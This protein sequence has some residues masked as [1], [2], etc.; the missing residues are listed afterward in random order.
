MSFFKSKNDTLGMSSP[1]TRRDFVNGTLA[2]A[3][4]ALMG[5]HAYAVAIRETPYAPSGSSWTGYGGIGDY[6][7][8]NGNTEAVVTA[9]HGIRDQL[10]PN[11]TENSAD[12]SFDLIIVGGGFSGMTAAYEFNKRA[13]HG[14]TCLLLENHPVI[15]GEAK[16]N[17]FIVDGKRLTAPQGSNGGIVL[18]DTFIKGSYDGDTYNVYTDYYREL[19]IP[20]HFDLE[21]LSGGAER[22]NIPNYHFAPM[23]PGSES[24]YETGYHFLGHGWVKNPV[25]AQFKNTPW[26]SNVQKE[27]DDFV[28]NRRGIVSGTDNV[29][30]WLDSV[31]YTDL[32]DKLGYGSQ[33][34]QYIDPYMAVANFGVC[35]NAISAYAAKRLGLPGTMRN[36]ERESSADIGVVSFPGGN[37]AI[38]RMMLARMIPNAINGNGSVTET[39]SAAINFNM[40]DRAGAPLRLR[41]GSTAVNVSHEGDPSSADYVIVTYVRDGVIRKARAKSVIMASGGWVNRNIVTDLS[42]TFYSAYSEFHHGPVLTANVALRNWR[43]FDKLGI[44]AARWFEGLGWHVSLRRNVVFENTQPLTPDDPIILTFY[45]PFLSPDLPPSAQGP[46]ARA[47]MFAKSYAEIEHQIRLKMTELFSV[48]GF[49][50]RHDIAGI[51]LN[52]WGHAFCAPQPGFFLGKT[53]HKAPHEVLRQPHG[54][55]IFA[56]SELHGLMSMAHAMTEGHRGAL[57]A[58]AML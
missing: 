2:G 37:A 54:R 48:A 52:R 18:K 7:W 3:G 26:P 4:A 49:D 29:D 45:I 23:A 22:Y 17:E 31:Y 51:I 30:S 33:V 58:M 12:E 42:E 20:T 47:T 32:L 19:G 8:A 6:S 14:Q 57:Q 13:N 34:R 41:L 1:I 27:M 5:R 55:I 21:Q 50:A 25:N 38:L 44:T 39:L 11:T 56:H 43:F 16:Q 9:A 10:Y 36:D 46:A 40:L 28:N 24:Y 15:G 35:G 53:N